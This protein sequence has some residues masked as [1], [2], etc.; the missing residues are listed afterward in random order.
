VKKIKNVEGSVLIV[1]F[2][3]ISGG[4]TSYILVGKAFLD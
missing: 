2:D 4:V 1:V 3:T